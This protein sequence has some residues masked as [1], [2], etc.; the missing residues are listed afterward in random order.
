LRRSI[1]AAIALSTGVVQ[2]GLSHTIHNDGIEKLDLLVVVDNSGSMAENQANIMAQLGPLI[3]QLTNP[4]CVS[5]AA[6]GAPRMCDPMNPDLVPMYRAV[7]DLHVGVI[8]TDLGTPGFMVRAAT[9]RDRGDDGLLN[10]IRNG[11]AMQTHLPWAPRRPNA[12]TAPPGFRPAACNNDINQ[13]PSFITFCSN[14][15]DA[16]CDIAGVNASSRDSAAFA[17]WFKCNAG[18]FINGCGLERSSSPCGARWSSTTRV[19]PGQHEPQRGLR[20]VR[21]ALAIVMLTDEDD[22]SVRELRARQRVLCGSGRRVHGRADVYNTA[23]G[24]WAHPTNPTCAST[25][26]RRAIARPELEPRSLRQHGSPPT[27][28]RWNKDLLSLK[29]GHPERIIF[30]AIAGVPLNIQTTMSGGNTVINWDSLLGA[31]GHER[32]RLLRPRLALRRGGDAANSGSV[33]DARGQH[34]PDVRARRARVPPRGK[35]VRHDRVRAR[36][37]STWPFRRGASSRSRDASTRPPS[38]TVSRAAAAS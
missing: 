35:H 26:T 23:S 3:D 33:L 27:P 25:S 30:A 21:R 11:L 22:G 20:A 31:P 32:G 17:D 38:A 13:F 7:R 28:T 15:A 2:M 10:P 37:R 12:V 16:S 6:P 29:P 18:I 34:G 4:P 14:A 9:T 5:R 8:S 36:T 24:A 19:T 1:A